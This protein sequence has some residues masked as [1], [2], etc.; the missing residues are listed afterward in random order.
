MKI[1]ELRQDS[2]VKKWMNNLK[3]KRNTELA[4]TQALAAYTENMRLTPKELIDE[5]D[6][7]ELNQ[8]RMRDRKIKDRLINFRSSMVN[9]GLADFTIRGRMGAVRSFYQSFDIELPKLQGERRKA[10]TREENTGIPIKE[11]LQAVLKVCDPLE[12]AIMLTGVSSGLSSVEIQNLTIDQFKK[13]YDPETEITTLKIQ[14][15]KTGVKFTTFLSPECSRAIWGYLEYRSREAKAA[16]WQRKRQL[17]KQRIV[18]DSGYLFILRQLDDSYLETQNEEER[19]LS[20]NVVQKLYRAISTKAKKDTK[21]NTYNVIRSHA[22]RKYFNS[23]LL[24][25]G[26]DSFHVEFFMGHELD[27]TRAAYFRAQP[28][29]LREIYQKYIPYLT[30]QKENSISDN[31]EF[32]QL[33]EDVQRLKGE[34][35][36]L[37]L[38]RFE[39]EAINKLK[40]DLD[41]LRKA[42]KEKEELER[43]FSE[44]I[45]GG[46]STLNQDEDWERKYDEHWKKL[47]TDPIYKMKFNEFEKPFLTEVFGADY[48]EETA[49]FNKKEQEEHKKRKTAEDKLYTALTGTKTLADSL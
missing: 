21:A 47:K 23:T 12:K 36:K 17:L 29:K 5:A 13:G 48:K 40:E 7:E 39:N 19:K 14:R 9:Q 45:A 37:K 6:K 22:M 10:R 25:A 16:T 31:P 4:Y 2:T 8:V 24:N 1:T 35:E 27:N 11:D 3:P 28:E 32:K 33:N 26:C 42:Q 30:I 41:E 34:N 49:A 46:F 44:I 15:T 38:D 18:S 20:G 43:T